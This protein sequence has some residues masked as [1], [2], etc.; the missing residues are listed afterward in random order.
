MNYIIEN[1]EL[2]KTKGE[3]KLAPFK[4]IEYYSR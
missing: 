4:I 2:D 3:Q 1:Y